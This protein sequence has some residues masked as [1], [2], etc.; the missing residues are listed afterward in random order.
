MENALALKWKD[1]TK[2]YK[3]EKENDGFKDYL[4]AP[5]FYRCK[6]CGKWVVSVPL[7]DLCP[8]FALEL[9]KNLQKRFDK[10]KKGS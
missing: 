4:D 10:E 9:L 6:N 1:F 3:D 2:Q 7:Q 5:E 8:D